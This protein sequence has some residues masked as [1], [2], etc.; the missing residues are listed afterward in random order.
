MEVRGKLVKMLDLEKGTSKAGKEWQKQTVVIDTGD[1]FNNLTAVSAFGDKVQK[2]NKLE[3][4][5]TV[6]ILCNVYSREYKGKYYH[7]IDGYH[8]T[9]QSENSVVSDETPF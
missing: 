8:F 7:N 3:V 1:E 6:A 2:M 9:Q 5:M 4:G